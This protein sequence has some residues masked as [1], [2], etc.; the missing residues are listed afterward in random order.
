M[1]IRKNVGD[2]LEKKDSEEVMSTKYVEFNTI[3]K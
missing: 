2:N 3:K 1:K